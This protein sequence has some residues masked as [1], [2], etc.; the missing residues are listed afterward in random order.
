MISK[1]AP[2]VSRMELVPVT[3]RLRG[4]GAVV[5]AGGAGGTVVVPMQP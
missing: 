3:T 1:R 4:S 5:G 2:I